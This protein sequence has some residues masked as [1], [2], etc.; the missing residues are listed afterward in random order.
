MR[1]H[2]GFFFIWCISWSTTTT[3][4]SEKGVFNI[5]EISPDKLTALTK[6][7]LGHLSK[8]YDLKPF[9][10]NKNILISSSSF[11]QNSNSIQLGTINA[12]KPHDL[13]AS[14]LHQEFRWWYLKNPKKF[15]LAIYALDEQYNLKKNPIDLSNLVICYLE[16]EALTFYLQLD[17]AKNIY[18]NLIINNDKLSWFFEQVLKDHLEIR[19]I[20]KRYNLLPAPLL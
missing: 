19:K 5:Q 20:F 9:I 14:W 17:V 6:Q 13:L 2:W 18:S 10:Y 4:Q 8:V 3:F 1:F 11:P 15:E 16:F 7:N 12:E